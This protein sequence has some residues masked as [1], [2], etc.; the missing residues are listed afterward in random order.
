MLDASFEKH[1]ESGKLLSISG[2]H[3]LVETSYMYCPNQFEKW[4][5]EIQMKG[6]DVIL[7]HPERYVYMDMDQYKLLKRSGVLF[8]LNILSLTGFYG[9]KAE[10]KAV[11][12]LANDFYN[13]LGSDL[14]AI[15]P[16]NKAVERIKLPPGLIKKINAIKFKSDF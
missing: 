8:Q 3:V 6:Y 9:S 16:F 11:E 15:K 1:L 4:I 10:K 12:L 7:A 5:S 14:H 2:R 13:L